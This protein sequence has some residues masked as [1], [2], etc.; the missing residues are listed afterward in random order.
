[1]ATHASLTGLAN[2]MRFNEFMTKA[3]ARSRR[4]KK[5]GSLLY[6]DLDG[7]KA[8]NDSYGHHMGDFLLQRV[9]DRLTSTLR[10][11]DFVA[12][13]GGDEFAVILE[14][15]TDLTEP[16]KVGQ[17]ILNNIKMPYEKEG[18]RAT[19]GVSIGIA[20]FS[21]ESTNE[22]IINRHADRAMC[23]AKNGGKGRICIYDPNIDGP[24]DEPV[25]S[26]L[27]LDHSRKTSASIPENDVAM[28]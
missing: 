2:R 3:M 17:K 4:S 6:L 5:A 8:V 21:P 1:M 18:K 16:E 27:E 20:Y 13:F 28:V 9:A 22:E 23:R 19:I 11:T 24:A 12:R 25:N 10:E 26:R 15:L 7:F 14:A